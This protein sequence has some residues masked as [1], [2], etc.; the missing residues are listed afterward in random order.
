MFVLFTLFRQNNMF[1]F[2]QRP[3]PAAHPHPGPLD[4]SPAPGGAAGAARS[5]H[6][7]PLNKPDPP[8]GAQRWD[9]SPKRDSASGKHRQSTHQPPYWEQVSWVR[10]GQNVEW[11]RRVIVSIF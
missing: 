2:F 8:W 7:P 5:L 9:G 4:P 11:P 10:L 3:Q 1:S 6:Q